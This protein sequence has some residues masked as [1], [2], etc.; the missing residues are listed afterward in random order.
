MA[1]KTV[2]I[3]CSTQ[4]L[5]FSVFDNFR[6]VHWG[7]VAFGK[8]DMFHRAFNANKVMNILSDDIMFKGVTNVTYEAPVYINNRKTVID[9][10]TLLG[11]AVSPLAKPGVEVTSVPPITW[12]SY[13]GNKIF[14]KPEKEA[15]RAKHPDKSQ[16]WLSGEMRNI[17]KQRTISW[18]NNRFGIDVTSDNVGDAIG[19]AWWRLNA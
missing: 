6:L 17:R 4:S 1:N 5:A 15:L 2:G 8:G 3:D 9:L 12:Q 16:T 14:T 18:A 19:V 13:I 11:A 10:A 7:E